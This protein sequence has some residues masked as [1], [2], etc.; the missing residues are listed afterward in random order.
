MSGWKEGNMCGEMKK[1]GSKEKARK[2][3]C[4]AEKRDG[5]KYRQKDG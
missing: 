5:G 1:K 4:V 3:R 2:Y